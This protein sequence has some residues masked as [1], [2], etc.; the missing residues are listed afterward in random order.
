ML[1]ITPNQ[2]LLGR[3][4]IEVPDL[5]YDE[6][7]KFSARLSYVQQVHQSWWERWIQDVLPTLVPCKRWKEIKKN[8][9]V[10]D[11]VLMK[12]DGNI[13]DD[14]RLAKVTEVFKDEKGLVRKVKVSF[15]RRDKRESR[16]VYWKKPLSSEIVAVQRLSLLQAAKE[17]IPDGSF[18]DQLPLDASGRLDSVKA[19][20]AAAKSKES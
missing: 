3:S 17:P 13:K 18:T 1:P 19:S 11:I 16:D 6:T 5:E 7:N 12:Y 14:Y 15:R 2:L 9:K 10:D 20:L 4:S 8:L